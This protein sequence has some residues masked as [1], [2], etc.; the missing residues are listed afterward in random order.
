MM[1]ILGRPKFLFRAEFA[2]ENA[3]PG[4]VVPIGDIELASR[5]S[6]FLWSSLP[7]AELINLAARGEL[8][9]GDN[10]QKEV[11]RMLADPRA[12]ALIDNFVFQWL[13]LRDLENIDPD[14]EIF[15]NYNRGLLTAFQDEISLFVSDLLR[16]NSSVLELMTS[17]YTYLNEDLAL[18]YGMTD[19]KGDNF[20]KV[21]LAQEERRGLLGKGGVQMVTSYANRTTPVIRGAYIM[22]NFQGVPPANPPPNV[23]A[24]P[25]TPE[26]VMVAQTVRER[27]AMHRDNPACAGC[28]D[29]MDP[30]GLAFEQFDHFAR[31]RIAE[32]VEVQR[33]RRAQL[34]HDRL[35]VLTHDPMHQ[36]PRPLGHTPLRN[37]PPDPAQPRRAGD[38]RSG[39]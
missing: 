11:E 36:H 3:A 4:A 9:Q 14:P 17:E 30:L 31:F 29:V 34:L 37:R 25:E 38:Q 6:F 1:A 32:I 39:T 19:I 21:H 20:R 7:D 22:E 15:A 26:G 28:H 12:I 5:L 16:E 35:T 27:L 18:H 13:R 10:L 33:P 23:E 8:R 24:F 2:P